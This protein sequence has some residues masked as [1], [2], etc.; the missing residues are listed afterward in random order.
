M[1]TP[2]EIITLFFNPTRQRFPIP[3]PVDI[4]FLSRD[5]VQALSPFSA[6]QLEQAALYLRDHRTQRTFPTIAECRHT[7][8][9][10]LEQRPDNVT[11][12][13]P[14]F[15]TVA[16]DDQTRRDAAA[17]CRCELGETAD[18]EGWLVALIDF[19]REHKRLPHGRE[20][21]RC[22]ALARRS[23]NGLYDCRIDPKT[24]RPSDLYAHLVKMRLA[25]LNKATFDVF[26]YWP[27][28]TR[29]VYATPDDGG[30]DGWQS[31]GEVADTVTR[32]LAADKRA[33]AEAHLETLRGQPLVVGE[34]LRKY[35]D[36]KMMPPKT[37]IADTQA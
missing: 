1:G 10:F 17:L 23:E 33:E 7:C 21:D 5:L 18:R 13:E 29:E 19:C 27:N 26:G 11:T 32:K 24:G 22:I 35:I 16:R 9:R 15:V 31:L 3:A 20:I 28:N 8:E 2:N 6:Y 14:E 25:M 12:Y 34:M 4:D 37:E 30:P 36:E